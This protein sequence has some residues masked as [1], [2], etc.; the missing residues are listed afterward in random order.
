[1]WLVLSTPA[2]PARADWSPWASWNGVSAWCRRH[3]VP[4]AS[5]VLH[6]GGLH[7]SPISGHTPA[8]ACFETWPGYQEWREAMSGLDRLWYMMWG[9]R[10][11]D[12]GEGCEHYR[13]FH[14]QFPDPA[15][16]SA[17][18]PGSRS[19]EVVRPCVW[20]QQG[21]VPK[22]NCFFRKPTWNSPL[23]NLKTLLGFHVFFFHN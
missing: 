1:M 13:A 9:G 17:D 19:A 8:P 18:G 14:F 3:T 23:K 16:G 5:C 10:S 15:L 7:V 20:T 22:S 11:L 4:S 6:V 21:H 12:R 2:T